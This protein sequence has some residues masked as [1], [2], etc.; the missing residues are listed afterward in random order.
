M[1]RMIRALGHAA[2]HRGVK[3]FATVASGVTIVAAAILA[4]ATSHADTAP[5]D[6]NNP[7]TP[8]TV[9][10]DALPTVQIDG[11]VWAQT[12]VGNNVYAVGRFSTAR[13]AGAALGS[14]TVSR[15]NILAYN[16]QTG[17]LIS[18]FAPTLNAQGLTITTSPDKSRLYVGGDFTSVSGQVRNRAVALNPST[19]AVLSGFAPKV[20]GSVRALVASAD[21]VWVGGNFTTVGS[22]A[23][24]RLAAVRATDGALLAWK[25]NAGGGKVNALVASPDYRKVVAGG[26]FTT[27]NGSSKPGFGLGAVDAVSGANLATPVNDVIRNG[28]DNAAITSLSSDGTHWYGSGYDFGGTGNLEGSF[29]AY[30]TN[31][32]IKWIEDCHGDTYSVFA[33][34]TAAYVAGHPHYCGNLGG[35]PETSPRTWHRALAFSRA[36]TRTLTADPYGYWSFTGRPAPEL[37]VWFPDMDT[38]SATGQNQG[39]WHVTGNSQ[40]ILMGGEFRNVNLKGQQGLVRFA[41]SSIAPDKE[42]PRSSAAAT[43]PALTSPSAGKITV[44]WQSNWDRDNTNLTYQVYRDS[45]VVNTQSKAT[46]FWNRPT[47]EYVDTVTPGTTHS[48]RVVVR[49]P[50][51]NAKS[52]TTVSLTAR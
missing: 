51:G 13:P 36:A 28:G 43:N 3:T 17:A 46:T 23:R 1:K 31:L 9:S 6:P 30:W 49:D 32:G 25:P 26:H 41:V 34:N 24:S 40:Y 19:G 37:L 16:L 48:Y 10:A 50:F 45:V 11:V 39:P 22:T 18:S 20:N 2:P 14:Q 12:I 4:P 7:K 21:T 33:N 29:A 47:M 44:R 5:T 35:F 52:S 38:G 8:V 27:M 42:G 15:S